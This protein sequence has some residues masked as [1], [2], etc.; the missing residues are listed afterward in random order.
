MPCKHTVDLRRNAVGHTHVHGTDTIGMQWELIP[1]ASLA[2]F[3]W[4]FT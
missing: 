3:E 1:G 4:D 2:D